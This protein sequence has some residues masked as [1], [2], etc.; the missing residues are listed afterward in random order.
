MQTGSP[1][2]VLGLVH[3]LA[4]LVALAA[5]YRVVASR[6]DENRRRHQVVTGLLFGAVAVVGM[7]TP[8]RLDEGLIFDGRSIVLGVGGFVGGPLV[9][10]IAG[11]VAAAYRASLGGVGMVMGILVIAEAAALG[12]AFHAWR[13]RIGRQPGT[14]SLVLFGLVIHVVMLGLM[15]TLPG[16]ARR[17]ALAEV[18]AAVL[19]LYPLVTV[20]AC[21][22]FLDYERSDREHR[23]LAAS[24][25]R[26]RT[27]WSAVGDAVLATDADGRVILLNPAAERLTG[28]SASEATGM[29]VS[30]VFPLVD[31]ASGEPLPD[32]VALALAGGE[33]VLPANAVLGARD[34]TRRA[35]ADS[36]RVTRDA[37]GAVTGAVVVFRD[38][39]AERRARQALLESRQRMSLALAGAELGTWD[40]DIRTGQITC[41]ARWAEML[42]LDPDEAERDISTW[43]QRVHPDDLPRV[44]EALDHHLHGRS[45][46]YETEHR[47]LHADGS[48][49]WV[50]DRGRVL[51][52]APD[53]APLRASG[54]HLDV[55]DR[56]RAEAERM[57]REERLERQNRIL[58]RLIGAGSVFS[59]ELKEAVAR[60]TEEGAALLEVDRASFWWYTDDFARVRCWD[61]YEPAS[62]L[63]AE[64]EEYPTSE[65]PTYV[66]AHRAG[67]VIAV[68]DVRDDPRTVETLAYLDAHGVRSLLDAPV[69]VGTEVVGILSFETVSGRRAW[70]RED[71]RLATTLSVIL[72]VCLEGSD[73][74]RA[75][76]EVER[77][78]G[79]LRRVEADLRESLLEA[80]RARHALLSALEDRRRAEES[81]RESEA[82]IR[83]VMDHLPVGV[84]VNTV[85]PAVASY[86]NEN[87]PRIYGTTAEALARPDGFWESVY[88]DPAF[89]EVMKERVLAD[90][91]S[92]DPERMH[93]E[94][95]PLV[96][97]SGETRYVSARNTPVPERGLMI[98]T[99]WDVTDRNRAEDALRESEARF[100]RLAENAPDLIYRY[101]LVPD[102]GFEY[103]SPAATAVTG[104]TPEEHYADPDLGFKMVHP[105]DRHLLAEAVEGSAQ[106]GEPLV[107]RW[108]AKDGRVLWTEQRNAPV[109]DAEGNVVA[110]EGIARDITGRKRAEEALRESEERYR[111]LFAS[112][113]QVLWVYDME[114]LAFLDV[115]DAAVASY[116][117]S[118][119]EFMDMTIADI[120]PADDVPAL[121]E[122]VR[123]A[124]GRAGPGIDEAGIWR[125]RKKDGTLI[126]VEI[127][128]HALDFAGRPA[129][130]VMVTDVTERLRQE[131]EIRALTDELEDRVRERTA[132]LRAANTELES[133]SYSVSHD[134]KAP[135][136]AIDGYS[137]LLQ[138]RAAASLDDDARHLVGEVRANAQQMGRLIEDL[139]AFSRV[140]RAALA[141]EDV[142][143]AEVVSALVERER[144][145]APGR[146]IELAMES[147]PAVRGDPLLIRQALENVLGNAVKFTRPREV[148]RIE[149]SAQR[150]EGGERITIRDNGVGFDP[151]YRHKLF[152]VFERLHYPDEFEGTGVGLAIVKRVMERHGGTVGVESGL[153]AGTAIFLTFPCRGG[154]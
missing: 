82:F 98:S 45:T 118:R 129:E 140:G 112:S 24:E 28:W 21:R 120:R 43:S 38:Q 72:S 127:R 91:A 62:G 32:P 99:V 80:D 115:N 55:T 57:A 135:L 16:T 8:V 97:A 125:H 42:G 35:V 10:L 56:K 114:T 119:D 100:R 7:M 70:S 73:R 59:A 20:L 61:A 142:D 34:G 130:L 47:L 15:F 111:E 141:H 81:V 2:V 109:R 39:S 86:M 88:R 6:W 58:F 75:E 51:E 29:P 77:Q 84:A 18:G 89:R 40:W 134:L 65:A 144:Q 106:E 101:R 19:V 71:E 25:A 92:G 147:L 152:R 123:Q 4:L 74:A 107:L 148:A 63:H 103:V 124:R 145:M 116:G 153:D 14:A 23:A 122:N 149:V 132:Q 12:A 136:R 3:N 26:Y 137:A 49:V 113:P 46:T 37:S 110:L 108:V 52:R 139:L 128:S 54:T 36:I 48:W 150:V 154:G 31:Q 143:L 138:E 85:E 78:L 146:R 93:W 41:N 30:E 67:E 94:D 27:L 102:R 117:Y 11:A 104:Y 50:L 95:V 44:L 90:V 131:R 76:Q 33:A 151:R 83:A 60:I 17:M 64:G 105:D 13:R 133:F 79:E 69:W 5:G 87:F 68:A 126:D 22:L 1:G 96:L 9:A 53:G 121:Q 66:A